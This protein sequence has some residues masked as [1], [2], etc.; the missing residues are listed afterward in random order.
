MFFKEGCRVTI[1]A[2]ILSFVLICGFAHAQSIDW[3]TL[4][5][6]NIPTNL[7][8][9]DVK[10]VKGTW[11][12][13]SAAYANS[14]SNGVHYN[15]WKMFYQTPL[16][17]GPAT[18]LNAYMRGEYNDFGNSR[19]PYGSVTALAQFGVDVLQHIHNGCYLASYAGFGGTRRQGKWYGGGQASLGILSQIGRTDSMSLGFTYYADSISD[20]IQ[21]PDKPSGYEFTAGYTHSLGSGLPWVSAS[22][23]AYRFNTGTTF[24]GWRLTGDISSPFNILSLKGEVGYDPYN[25]NYRSLSAMLTYF[26]SWGI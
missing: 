3:S 18:F 1:T 20:P 25:G 9:S 5:I 22:I 14:Y 16:K 23:G 24:N 2:L 26:F 7:P 17:M 15:Q 4:T 19:Q 13:I 8:G 6:D 12:S 10:T 21:F 11:N